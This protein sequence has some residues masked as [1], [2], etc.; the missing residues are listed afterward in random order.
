MVPFSGSQ[1]SWHEPLIQANG[2]PLTPVDMSGS[3]AHLMMTL[4][5]GSA[6]WCGAMGTR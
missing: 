1:Q 5:F 4:S 6:L 2:S 3:T